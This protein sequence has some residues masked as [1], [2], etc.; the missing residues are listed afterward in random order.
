MEYY[1]ADN[2]RALEIE[3]R[4]LR[5]DVVKRFDEPPRTKGINSVSWDL[6]RASNGGRFGRRVDAGQY[7]VDM[8]VGAERIIRTIDIKNDPQSPQR[9]SNIADE[10]TW[11]M[12]IGGLADKID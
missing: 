4:N 7:L 6:R 1:L 10:F 9:G 5:G 8:R 11:W 2:E 3:I 12:Y